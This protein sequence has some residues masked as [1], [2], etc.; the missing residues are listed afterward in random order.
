MNLL[1]YISLLTVGGLIYVFYNVLAYASYVK[2]FRQEKITLSIKL[3]NPDP[4][5]YPVI[6]DVLILLIPSLEY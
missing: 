4:E 6:Y 2:Q 3:N 1:K 5:S